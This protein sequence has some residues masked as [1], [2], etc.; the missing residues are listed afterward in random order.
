MSVSRALG[1]ALILLVAWP[2]P[3]GAQ[4]YEGHELVRAELLANTT[5]VQPGKSFLV[6]VRLQMV[7]GWH[8]YWKFPGDAGIPTEIKWKLPPGWKAGE[9]QW[10]IPQKLV[11]P[12]DIQIYGY[13]DEVFLT[14]EITP[15]ATVTDSAVKLAAE[16]DWL[17]CEK[18]CIPGG[19]S[20]QL[21]LPVAATGSKSNEEIFDRYQRRLPQP[22]PAPE[23]ASADWSRNS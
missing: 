2:R 21:D 8:T 13:H 10:P 16:V 17:V 14:Q 15:P 5:A 1:L 18:I 23:I 4:V 22:W 3:S 12:G 20:L 9:I 7:P 19:T 6:G 11:E